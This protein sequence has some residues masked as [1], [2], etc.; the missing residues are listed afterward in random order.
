MLPSYAKRSARAKRNA[1]LGFTYVGVLCGVALIGLSLGGAA[2][3]ASKQVERQ[4]A[5][6]AD[7]VLLQYKLALLSYYKA[8]PG[9]ERRMPVALEDLLIDRRYLGVVRHLRRLYEVPCGDGARAALSYVPRINAAELRAT[10][11]FGA[12]NLLVVRA[13]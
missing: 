6:Q 3:L 12:P 1:L 10:C 4:R 7:W 11:G 9:A 2:Q 13:E 5:A 8:A